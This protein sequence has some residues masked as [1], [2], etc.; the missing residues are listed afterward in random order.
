MDTV[1]F[2]RSG[3]WIHP[4]DQ[5]RY[6]FSGTAADLIAILIANPD[7][8]IENARFLVHDPDNINPEETVE[9]LREILENDARFET[10]LES[11]DR[12]AI[13]NAIVLITL[14]FKN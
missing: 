6:R 11:E 10:Y 1:I 5:E 14:A 2:L 8:S 9:S 13:K 7:L 3:V 12:A 4:A